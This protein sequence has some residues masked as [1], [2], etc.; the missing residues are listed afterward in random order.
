MS[1]AAGT[2]A[3]QSVEKD[4]FLSRRKVALWIKGHALNAPIDQCVNRLSI[5]FPEMLSLTH[6]VANVL[7]KMGSVHLNHDLFSHF[8]LF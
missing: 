2:D 6:Y 5:P 4:W 8:A 3:P 7:L 1:Q